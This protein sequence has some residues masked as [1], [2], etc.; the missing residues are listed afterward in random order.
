MLPTSLTP[1]AL[2]YTTRAF[3]KRRWSS[4]THAATFEPV[5][6]LA[7]KFFALWHSSK[8]KHPEAARSL[9]TPSFSSFSSSPPA[10]HSRICSSLCFPA[11]FFM[12][13]ALYVT[14]STPSAHD[15]LKPTARVS[16][17]SSFTPSITRKP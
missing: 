1:V 12:T 10:N 11:A 7:L 6:A 3:G 9:F 17:S 15:L 4:I 13:S 5:S 8:I 16:R 2:Q 14:N